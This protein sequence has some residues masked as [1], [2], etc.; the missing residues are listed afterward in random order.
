MTTGK[1]TSGLLMIMT[2]ALGT[3]DAD[4]QTF[5]SIGAGNESVS[6]NMS[7]WLPVPVQP[8]HVPLRP[9]YVYDEYVPVY[10]HPGKKARK[11]ARKAR[12][13]MRKARKHYRKAMRHASRAR[14]AFYLPGGVVEVYPGYYYDDDD[15]NRH[16]RK[17]HRRHHHD[18]DDDDDDD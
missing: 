11:E 18:Y 16:Y 12:K 15:D 5:F 8:V 17:H 6:F 13:E 7:T 9:G 2:A 14:N 1:L 4:A 10:H 3:L